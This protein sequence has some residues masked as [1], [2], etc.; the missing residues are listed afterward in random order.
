[1]LERRIGARTAIIL[2]LA[3][4]YPL[5]YFSFPFPRQIGS[6]FWLMLL[7]PVIS[8]ATNFDLLGSP[9]VVLPAIV[10]DLSFLLFLWYENHFHEQGYF[11]DAEQKGE[12]ALRILSLLVVSY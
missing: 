2:N 8:A 1:M 7:L 9:I 3:L 11:L 5:I 6:S 4:C 12:L 10:E